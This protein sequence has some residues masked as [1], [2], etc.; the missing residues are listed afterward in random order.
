VLCFNIITG[1]YS[2]VNDLLLLVLGPFRDLEY[3]LSA[4]WFTASDKSFVPVVVVLFA[5]VL[6]ERTLK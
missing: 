4:N 6:A 1:F 3:N 5:N 2:S